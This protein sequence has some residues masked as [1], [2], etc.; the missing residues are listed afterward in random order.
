M[1]SLEEIQLFTWKSLGFSAQET[2]L[3]QTYE[4]FE[5]ALSF[6]FNELIETDFN[7]FVQLL[8]RLDINEGK[9]KNALQST[10]EPSGIIVAKLV[11]L[12]MEEKLKYRKGLEE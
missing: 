4:A 11:I 7:A 1:I 8:Y 9:L 12:R 2:K 3:F 10:S 5:E 6:Y